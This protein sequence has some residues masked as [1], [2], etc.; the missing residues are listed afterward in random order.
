[1]NNNFEEAFSNFL[2]RREY[3][4]A[5]NALFSIVRIAFV[6][7]WISAGGNPPQPQ[8]I[9]EIVHKEIIATN[10]DIESDLMPESK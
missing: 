1:M 8:R 4:K 5:E 7:G 6:A 9:L 10:E 2:E 3:D